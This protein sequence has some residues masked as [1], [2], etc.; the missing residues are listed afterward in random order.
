MGLFV[1]GVYL[2]DKFKNK[3]EEENPSATWMQRHAVVI[4]ALAIVIPLIVGVVIVSTVDNGNEKV[5]EQ[6][7]VYSPAKVT[8]PEPPKPEPVLKLVISDGSK[9]T[10]VAALNR[11]ASDEVTL[12]QNGIVQCTGLESPAVKAWMADVRVHEKQAM[13]KFIRYQAKQKVRAHIR[14]F[15][16][17]HLR[18]HPKKRPKVMRQSFW[19]LQEKPG[20]D[21]KVVTK[22]TV[23]KKPFKDRYAALFYFLALVLGVL[24][25]YYW[26]YAD[27]KSKGLSVKF[28]PHLIVMSFII[29]AMVYYSIQQGLEKEA[30]KLSLRGVIFAFNNGLMWQTV[31]TKYRQRGKNGQ[32]PGAPAT[33]QPTA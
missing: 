2:A 1:L 25:T 19:W 7:V 30:D 24:G 3:E 12:I 31:L 21:E 17:K 28:Q 10:D 27:Q 6:K 15:H 14:K 29:A 11:C 9:E 23:K 13:E 4:G 16:H 33:E 5:T 22:T 32:A 8:A 18:V 26:D 20:S